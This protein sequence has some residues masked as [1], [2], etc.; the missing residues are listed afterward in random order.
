M[1]AE[2][3]SCGDTVVDYVLILRRFGSAGAV[4]AWR[5][6]LPQFDEQQS[7]VSAQ[8]RRTI[9]I[10]YVLGEI[11]SNSRVTAAMPGDTPPSF[12]GQGA[13]ATDGPTPLLTKEK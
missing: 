10:L 12:H 13:K 8:G 2:A 11:R 3:R 9:S 5:V 1:K 6:N 7:C 4:L